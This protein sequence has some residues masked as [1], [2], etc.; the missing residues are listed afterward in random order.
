MTHSFQASMMATR[1]GVL[2]SLGVG[3]TAMAL[4]CGAWAQSTNAILKFGLSTFPPTVKPFDNTGGAANTVKLM[5]YRGLMGYDASGKLLPELAESFE[6]L[7]PTVAVFKLRAK[8]TFHN[9][10]PVTAADVVFSLNEIT[11]EGSSAFLKSDLTIITAAE[12]VDEKTVQITLSSPSAIF[13][14]LMASYCCPVIS[15]ESTEDNAIGAGPFVMKSSEKGV[16]IE[17]ER[18]DKYYADDQPHVGGIRFIAYADENLRFAALEAGDVDLIEYLPWTQFD[19]VEASDTM[20]MRSTLGP[21]MF[22]LFNVTDGPFADAKVRQAVGYAIERQ[23][24]VDAAFAGRGVPLY[25]FPNPQGSPFDLTDPAHEWT[26]DAEKAKALLA[27]AGYP[28]GFDCRLLAT[29]TYGMHQDT[30]SV[31]QAYLAMIGI[32]AT[33]DLPDW[34]TRVT[35]GK[36]GK[37]DLAVHGSS[38]TYND[39]DS[40][41]SLLYSGNPSYLQ[42]FG[43]KSARIDG[44]LEQGRTEV[45]PEKRK[46]IYQDLATAYFEEVPQ[47]P[48]NWRVQAYAMK[49]TVTGFEALPGFLNGASAYALDDTKLG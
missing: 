14:D 39:P 30:A 16:F 9:G 37:Y 3:I 27:E 5:I 44:L 18:F 34:G 41:W 15:A 13:L 4:P 47:V 31:V 20:Q 23:D 32:N 8:A 49:K 12:A 33:L 36:E 42:S 19:A 17:L 22:L 24:V 38:G 7:E 2:L 26:F 10:K 46:A 48:L 25:G 28:N 21:Y 40:L 45:D 35:A 43:F 1:R 6:W 11:K 29:A